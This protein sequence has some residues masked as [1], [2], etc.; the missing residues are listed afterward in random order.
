MST[1]ILLRL[2]ALITE[3]LA[4]PTIENV[5][6]LEMTLANLQPLL[7]KVIA[8]ARTTRDDPGYPQELPQNAPKRDA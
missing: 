8:D 4:Q 1:T 2:I 6:Q 3:V 7:Q 5:T